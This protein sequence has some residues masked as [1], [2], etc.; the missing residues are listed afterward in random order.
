[1]YGA[2]WSA[3]LVANMRTKDIGCIL[4]VLVRNSPL[5]Q[6]LYY[7][8][9]RCLLCICVSAKS[10]TTDGINGIR[11]HIK[12]VNDLGIEIN[13]GS[14]LVVVLSSRLLCCVTVGKSGLQ[15]Q[16]QVRQC[17]FA[18]FHSHSK[19]CTVQ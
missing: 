15:P 2:E 11:V 14:G 1:M 10:T 4:S 7:L 17:R 8:F 18:N 16:G 13:H 19:P 3:V 5:E 12:A 9:G 6:R